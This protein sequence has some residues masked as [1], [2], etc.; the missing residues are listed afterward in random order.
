M[1][2]LFLGLFIAF[3]AE[4]IQSGF[5]EL[6]DLEGETGI[7]GFGSIPLVRGRRKNNPVDYLLDSRSRPTPKHSVLFR[8]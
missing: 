4:N 8:A 2:G 7:P 3:V 5:N 1:F 6:E